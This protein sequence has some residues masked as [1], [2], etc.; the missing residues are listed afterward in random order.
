M[1]I[2]KM[3]EQELRDKQELRDMLEEIEMYLEDEDISR[4]VKLFRLL[5]EAKA[6]YKR[7]IKMADKTKTLP[8]MLTKHVEDAAAE[9][10]Q[11]WCMGEHNEIDCDDYNEEEDNHDN[12]ENHEHY[13][14]SALHVY[15]IVDT[16]GNYI[17]CE[18]CIAAGGP[19]IELQTRREAVIG[20]W[21]DERVNRYYADSDKVASYWKQ[22]YYTKDKT[23]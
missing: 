12:C 1:K 6:R 4:N 18:V 23:T 10:W 8:E 19:Y 15:H 21:C 13:T 3:R 7:D 2:E 14:E 22:H 17:G 11:N 5:N 9:P 16:K 20:F